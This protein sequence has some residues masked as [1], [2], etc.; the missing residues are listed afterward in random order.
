LQAWGY[1]RVS[2]ADQANHGVSL[3]A[4]TAKI[5]QWCAANGYELVDVL[6]D[7]GISGGRCDNR[8]AL[9]AALKAVGRGDALIVYSLSRL[10]RSIK[11]TLVVA[12]ALERRGAD[13]VS[14]SERLDTSSASGKMLF[15]MVAVMAEFEKNVIGERTRMGMAQLRSQ[16]KFCGGRPPTGNARGAGGYL[17]AVPE[18]QRALGLA[19]RMRKAGKS[20]RQI[21]TALAAK[22]LLSRADTPFSAGQV[23]RMLGEHRPVGACA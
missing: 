10:A 21:S 14:L 9:Q 18:E 6:V 19:R 4:Q 2:S 23:R 8:P 11:D 15:H 1:C 3:D 12:E 17:V 7:A 22:G 16:G 13:L 5:R 20:L